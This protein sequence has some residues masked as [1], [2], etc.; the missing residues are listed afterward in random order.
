MNPLSPD[1]NVD[2]LF[3]AFFKAELPDPWPAAPTAT[4]E[5]AARLTQ[6]AEAPRNESPVARRDHNRARYTLA[7]SVALL[8]GTCWALSDGSQSGNRPAN[9][10]GHGTPGDL[11]GP[12]HATTP[13]EIRDTLKNPPVVPMPDKDD[14][15]GK[16]N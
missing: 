3:S 15:L 11:L 12:S 8:L 4:S 16:S 5:A 10:P 13:P 1:E 6:R 2:H 14:M 9:R 7:A